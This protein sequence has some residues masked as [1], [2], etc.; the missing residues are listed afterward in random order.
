MYCRLL[1]HWNVL[2]H[3]VVSDSL[4]PHGLWPTRLL[5][6]WGFSRQEYWSGL[7]CPPSGIFPTQGS[8]PSFP[9]CRQTL[10]CL[11]HQGSPRMLERVAY[12]F[13]RGSSQPRN[14]TGVSCTAGR[15]LPAELSGKPHT[16]I[17]LISLIEYY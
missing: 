3:S 17:L 14:G 4:R 11:S 12:P 5:C 2:S 6:S 15:F 8:N 16:G 10:Y 9:H 1:I 7:P 13:S